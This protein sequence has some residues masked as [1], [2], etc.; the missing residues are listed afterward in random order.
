MQG[1]QNNIMD[2]LI[3]GILSILGVLL[4]YLITML[5][6]YLTKK[7][8]ILIKQM[9]AQQYN[10]TYNIAK[11]IFY[12]VEQQFKFIPQAGEEK[13]KL[14]D[15]LL[16]KQIP[17]LSK[18]ELEHFREAIVGEINIQLKDSKLFDPAPLFNN[19]KDEGDPKIT[20]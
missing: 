16:L 12:A 18:E 19:L 14:F 8:E 17:Q 4:S 15:E 10:T 1:L 5:V 7:K 2:I 11:S 13:K 3:Q 20:G 6:S 9:G